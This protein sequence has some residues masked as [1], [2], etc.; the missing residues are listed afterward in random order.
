MTSSD[1]RAANFVAGSAKGLS[2]HIGINRVDPSHY[3]DPMPLDGSEWDAE[4]MRD[5]AVATGYRAVILPSR[6]GT[7][8]AVVNAITS[9][10]ASLVA[11]DI[12][13]VTYSG[14]GGQVG[15]SSGDEGDRQDETWC[16]YDRQLLDDQLLHLWAKFAPGVRIVVVSDSCHSGTISSLMADSDVPADGRA[17]CP[18]RV[19]AMT[20]ERCQIVYERNKALYDELLASYPAA[21]ERVSASVLTLSA[22]QDDEL[23]YDDV[24]NGYYT[25]ALREVWNRGN[26]TGNYVQFHQA[27]RNSPSLD[28]RMHP[29]LTRLTNAAPGFETQRVFSI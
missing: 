8:A 11:G 1:G 9:A 21:P 20:S 18:P 3:G 28:P 10:A 15:D 23:S 16:L 26:F 12:F 7:A 25:A 27:I 29:N 17:K 14:H 13:L 24:R 2:L 4:D 5:I 22:C 19:R 6:K